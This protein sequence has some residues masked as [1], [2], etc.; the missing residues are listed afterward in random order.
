MDGVKLYVRAGPDVSRAVIA[1][2]HRRHLPVTAHLHDTLPSA[3]AAMGID[4]LEHITT[5]FEELRDLP[6]K[7][8]E[9]YQATFLGIAEVDLNGAKAQHLIAAVHR[10]HVAVTPTLSV[11]L[12]P[13]EGETGAAATYGDWA[14]VPDGWRRFWKDPYWDFLATKGWTPQDFQQA[15]LARPQFLQLV[16]RLHKAGVPIVAGTD[17]PAP[18]V[19]PG[20]GLLAELQLLVEA[21]LSPSDALQA[22]TGRAAAVLH[23]AGDV[24]TLRPGRYAD[25]LLLDA[26]PLLDIRNLRHIAAV[27]MNGKEIDR[28]ALRKLFK[29]ADPKAVKT[30]P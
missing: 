3:A 24:G 14:A 2:A 27:Y 19:L 26:D 22:A 9:G 23:K 29:Q 1:E 4:N 20:A 12:L 6:P 11:A 10:H 13:V 25:L 18:W 8:A 5:L 30:G 7:T 21:G 15:H 28:P 17:T 16:R